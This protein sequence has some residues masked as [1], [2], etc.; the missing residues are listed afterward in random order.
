[1]LCSLP[2]EAALMTRVFVRCRHSPRSRFRRRT[3]KAAA[4]SPWTFRT[5][6]WPRRAA[7]MP[8]ENSSMALAT[9][10]PRRGGAGCLQA[11]PTRSH[12]WKRSPLVP[13]GRAPP[14][15]RRLA[16]VAAGGVAKAWRSVPGGLHPRAAARRERAGCEHTSRT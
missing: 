3:E 13:L 12:V 8:A 1:M 15:E 16:A 6:S 5:R 7:D 11:T 14:P 2:W 10:P 4:E 9:P